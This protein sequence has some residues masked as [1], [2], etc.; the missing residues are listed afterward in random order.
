MAVEQM[1][2]EMQAMREQVAA[3]QQNL[4]QTQAD[5]QNLIVQVNN[6]N[7]AVAAVVGREGQQG[8]RRIMTL[9]EYSHPNQGIDQDKA[10]DDFLTWLQQLRQCQRV[11]RWTLNTTVGAAIGA[12][13]GNAA[14]YAKTLPQ[15]GDAYA[16]LDA[17]YEQLKGKFIDASYQQVAEQRFESRRQKVGEPLQVYHGHLKELWQTAYARQEEAWRYVAGAAIPAPYQQGEDVGQRSNVLK[18]KFLAGIQDK[19]L[20]ERLRDSLLTNPLNLYSELLTRAMSLESITRTVHYAASGYRP[21][22]A[23]RAPNSF[24]QAAPSQGGPVPMEIGALQGAG[25]ALREALHE[26]EESGDAS[27]LVAAV[28]Q[29][30]LDENS[31]EG[32]AYGPVGAMGRRDGSRWCTVHR[33]DTH[34]TADCW[35]RRTGGGGSQNAGAGGGGARPKGAPPGAQCY[36]CKGF[37]HL[38]HQC[39][40]KKWK[41][42]ADAKAKAGKTGA[43]AENKEKEELHSDSETE[44]VTGSWRQDQGNAQ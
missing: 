40:N 16:D 42:A 41:K 9:R 7:A 2:A 12:M 30:A 23:Y 34:N 44:E 33:V 25:G 28:R 17:F 4:Q 39:P 36:V 19:R 37:G 26:A 24:P 38:S 21:S 35:S 29:L 15:T 27:N 1:Q 3:L 6:A 31:G 20:A 32:Q 11:N 18:H 5:N 10:Q 8:E 22:F 14:T 13:T 43:M